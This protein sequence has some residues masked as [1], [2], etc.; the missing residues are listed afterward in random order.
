M[1]ELPDKIQE[2][3][4]NTKDIIICCKSGQRS[5]QTVEFLKSVGIN[6]VYDGGGWAQI[7][8]LIK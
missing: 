3:K 5:Q 1:H 7:D 6:N 2:I 8:N 4:K